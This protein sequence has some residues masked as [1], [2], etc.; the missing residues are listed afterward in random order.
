MSIAHDIY[1]SLRTELLHVQIHR[2]QILREYEMHRDWADIV[3]SK[4]KSVLCNVR[5]KYNVDLE[6]Y[7]SHVLPVYERYANR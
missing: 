4:V 2:D 3:E 7:A 6:D 1:H 5:E